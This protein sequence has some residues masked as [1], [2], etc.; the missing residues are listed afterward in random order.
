MLNTDQVVIGSNSNPSFR[1]D[2]S[3]ISAYKSGEDEAYDLK[4]FVRYDQYGLYGIKN[5]GTFK[6]DSLQDV[7]DNAHF[8]VTWD[9]FFIK[10][11]YEDGGRVSITSDNDFQVIDGNETERIKIGSL[12]IDPLTNE[13]IYGINISNKNGNS[14]LS[15]NNN[16]DLVISGTIYA[17]AGEIGGMSVNQNTLRMNHTVFERGR[18]IYSD[19]LTSNNEPVFIISDVDGTAVFNAVTARGHIEAA[20]GTLG[21]LDVIDTIT[22]GAAGAIESSNYSV[23]NQTGWHI[24]DNGATFNNANVRGII[25]ALQG[26][27]LGMIRVGPTEQNQEHIIIDGTRALL[28]SSNF[29]EGAGYGWMINKDGDAVFNNITA[30][31]AI[32]TAVFEYAEIQAVGGIFIFR[33][34][35]TIK[36]ARLDNNNLVLKVEKPTL[37]AKLQNQEYS[38]CKISNYTTDGTEPNVQDILLTNG[39]THVYKISNVNLNTAEVTLEDGAQFVNA[40][41]QLDQSIEDVLVGLEGGALVDMGREDGSSNYGIGVNSSDNTVNLPRRAISLFETVVDKTKSPKISYKYQGIFGTLPELSVNDVDDSIYNQQMAGTQGIYTD[42]IYLGD[43]RQYV[44]FYEDNN[45]NKQLK[46]KANQIVYEFVDEE[47]G[48]SDW[49][50]VSEVAQGADGEDAIYI[51]I[52]STAG[53]FFNH[54]AVTTSLIAHVYQ[55][56]TEITSQFD[57]F[58]WYRRLPDGTRDSTWHTQE[59]SNRLDLT[60]ADVNERA[61]FVCEVVIS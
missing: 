1:W 48:E 14:V 11:S 61:V 49:K 57:T 16:G 31:G 55:G 27:F 39:L 20:T 32:K 4:T 58:E 46:I 35:S 60:T 50:D 9:G 18:G 25:T 38:W 24:D 23:A 29:Q 59:T 51:M 21:D 12:G 41:I 44:A 42:N 53:N 7:K 26:D 19:I 45:G 56:S 3:G 28:K 17:N 40:V 33:P 22:V 52:D 13:R 43:N 36:K 6:A 30:R 34:S 5:N 54:G 2:K 37:F 15:T 8:A 10:N 47:T